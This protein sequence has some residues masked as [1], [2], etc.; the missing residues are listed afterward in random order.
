MRQLGETELYK[1]R[2]GTTEQ[3]LIGGAV[4]SRLNQNV[5][6]IAPE[7]IETELLQLRTKSKS[8]SFLLLN[9]AL[10]LFET[11]GL[12]RLFDLGNS[13][14]RIPAYMPFLPALA[15]KKTGM[16]NLY[17]PASGQDRI[18]YMNMYRIGHWNADETL[19]TGINATTD[20]YSCLESGAI[21]Y[22]ML[23]QGMQDKV[24]NDKNVVEYST[25]LYSSLFARTMTKTK[26]TFGGQD[27][28]NDAAYFLIAK[29]FLKYVLGKNNN[30]VVNDYA[31]LVIPNKSSI[32]SLVSFE[33]TYNIDFSSFSGFLKTFGDAFYNEPVNLMEFEDN[34]VKICGEG[35]AFAVEYVPYF[36][37]FLFAT[38]H[39]AILGGSNRLYKSGPELNKLGLTKLYSAVINAI[40]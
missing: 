19:Y 16:S 25:R 31:H 28:Q 21:M 7:H 2:M 37:H 4:R 29:F 22:K 6:V 32:E 20:L 15:P 8:S 34:W 40:R 9:E 26:V 24:F 12:V 17:D 5:G 39:G 3:N 35:S 13:S 30:D 33:E 14:T 38:L 23:V 18:I 11:R 27:Y 1:L 36:F 10:A